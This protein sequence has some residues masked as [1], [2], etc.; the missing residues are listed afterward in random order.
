MLLFL[1]RQLHNFGFRKVN[2]GVVVPIIYYHEDATDDVMSILSIKRVPPK[3]KHTSK[4]EYSKA[5]V[6]RRVSGSDDSVL[7]KNEEIVSPARA[8]LEQAQPWLQHYQEK[9][10]FNSV[11]QLKCFDRSRETAMPGLHSDVRSVSNESMSSFHLSYDNNRVRHE[12]VSNTNF[13]SLKQCDF[14]LK[15]KKY[16]DGDESDIPNLG[17]FEPTAI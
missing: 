15:H 11:Q 16:L 3:S 1:Q 17:I 6:V 4:P 5:S 7:S 12:S 9:H 14:F 13:V 8:W 2:K 10:L